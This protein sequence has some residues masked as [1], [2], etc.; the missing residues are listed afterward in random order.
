MSVYKIS[1]YISYDG[2]GKTNQKYQKYHMSTDCIYQH[3]VINTTVLFLSDNFLYDFMILYLYD[4][5]SIRYAAAYN[6]VS[7]KAD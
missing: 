6:L 2:L 1:D 4:F 5:A 3:Q 7:Q